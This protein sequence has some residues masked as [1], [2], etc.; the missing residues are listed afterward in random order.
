MNDS[1]DEKSSC[2]NLDDI[3]HILL[4][5]SRPPSAG[6]VRVPYASGN[7]GGG[8]AWLAGILEKVKSAAEVRRF[9]RARQALGD[10]GVY[11]E[12]AAGARCGR[13]FARHVPGGVPA[14][15]GG[16][17]GDPRRHREATIPTT[18][19]AGWPARTST[20]SS[21]S[22]PATSRSASAASPGTR[23]ILV[24][25]PGVTVLSTLDLEARRRSTMRTTTSATATGCPAGHR[26]DRATCP[27][28]APARP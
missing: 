15:H 27:R 22:S 2:S 10:R 24:A 16:P 5:A 18:G 19:W 21:S 28:P 23:A 13:G 25:A 7:P 9:G 3:Q 20:P 14:R 12:R 6:R 17:R 26:R 1:S 8:R 11:L 4:T